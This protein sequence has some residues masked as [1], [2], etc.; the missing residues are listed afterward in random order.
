M[1]NHAKSFFFID[2]QV[3]ELSLMTFKLQGRMVVRL[4]GAKVR[5]SQI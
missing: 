3:K 5:V 4:S 1:F 2:F